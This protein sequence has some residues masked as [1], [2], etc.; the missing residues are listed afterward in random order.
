MLTIL[1]DKDGSH[2]HRGNGLVVLADGKEIA[3]SDK[4][5]KIEGK[6]P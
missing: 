4:I 5:E 3:R 2:Y 6:L 1:W